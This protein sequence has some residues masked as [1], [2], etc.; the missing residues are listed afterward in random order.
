MGVEAFRMEKVWQPNG[1]RGPRRP[2]L[3][4]SV[5]YDRLTDE[6]LAFNAGIAIVTRGPHDELSFGH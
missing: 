4:V 2:R 6:C 5:A 1:S 3:D